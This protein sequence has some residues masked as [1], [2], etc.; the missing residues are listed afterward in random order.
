MTWFEAKGKHFNRKKERRASYP[1]PMQDDLANL[2][3]LEWIML[4]GFTGS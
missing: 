1:Y 2:H 3:L 4:E